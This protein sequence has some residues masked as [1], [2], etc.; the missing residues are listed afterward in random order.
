M[1]YEV[2]IEI[3][4]HEFIWSS[5][6]HFETP[7]RP[8]ITKTNLQR[9]FQKRQVS[10]TTLMFFQG[11]HPILGLGLGTCLPTNGVF[12]KNLSPREGVYRAVA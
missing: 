8:R 11:R 12:A 5:K 4:V 1:S 6:D 9:V 3:I 10:G 7:Y 2:N